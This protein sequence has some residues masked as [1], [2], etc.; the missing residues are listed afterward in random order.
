MDAYLEGEDLV[1]KSPITIRRTQQLETL[2]QRK[3]HLRNMSEL[4]SAM[5]RQQLPQG[6]CKDQ[7]CRIY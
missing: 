2:P 4:G 7:G 3:G 5:D 1:L 6:C